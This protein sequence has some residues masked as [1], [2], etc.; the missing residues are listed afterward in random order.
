MRSVLL[1][2]LLGLGLAAPTY[3][4]PT[5]LVNVPTAGVTPFRSYHFGLYNYVQ[6]SL[7]PTSTSPYLAMGSFS[8]GLVPYFD[9]APG[10]SAGA[11]ELGVDGFYPFPSSLYPVAAAWPTDGGPLLAQPHFKLGLL[12]ETDVLPGLAVGSYFLSLP[13]LS[14][15]ANMLHASA[16]KWVT[17]NDLDLGQFTL[18]AYH[19]NPV[20]LGSS[21]NG[22]MAG[23]YHNLPWNLYAMGDYTSGSSQISGANL[24]L[25]YSVN[26]TLS[27]TGGYFLSGRDQS[28]NKAFLFLD[29]I[30]DLPM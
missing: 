10:V 29:W 16:T 4:Y 17:V 11:V 9:L 23:Y 7:I 20:A 2:A 21:A 25:G 14:Y 22:W 5:A 18:T 3:A 6:P 15:G 1:A 30:G 28:E 19:G 26:R 24:A 13:D 27:V 8:I 12:Q